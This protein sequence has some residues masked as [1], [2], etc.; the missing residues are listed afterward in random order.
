MDTV[1]TRVIEIERQSAMD[2]KRA[3]VAYHK[4][5]EA[6]RRTLE[7]KKERAH[8]QIISTENARLTKN[9]QELNKQTEE[10]F[11]TSAREYENRFQDAALIDAVKE[12]IIATLLK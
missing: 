7:E 11:L 3:E 8:A 12:K 4:N 6:H 2:I 10:K 9:L 5:I 1:I